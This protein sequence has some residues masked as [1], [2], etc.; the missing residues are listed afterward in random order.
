[1][2]GAEVLSS[3]LKSRYDREKQPQQQP[4]RVEARLETGPQELEL[5]PV[6]ALLLSGGIQAKAGP[7]VELCEQQKTAFLHFLLDLLDEGGGP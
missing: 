3:S 1:M 2:E 5:E 4:Q 6:W 7:V